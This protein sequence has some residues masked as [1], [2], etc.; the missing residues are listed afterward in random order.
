DTI[1]DRGIEGVKVVV[2]AR[3][4][5]LTSGSFYW[6]FKNIEDLLDAV[7]DYWENRL[8]VQIIED[9]VAFSGPPEQRILN[10]MNQVIEEDAAVPDS[11]IAVWAKSNGNAR[12]AYWRTMQRRFDFAAWMFREAGF[13]GA[14]AA[15]RGRMMVT[16]LMGETANGIGSN[17]GWR[18][19]I[20]HQWRILVTR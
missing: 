6:H 17:P 20:E 10:L 16:A 8:T 5:G 3:T 9:A 14:G 2:L 15:A 4:L 7:L 1:H 19:I 18:D 12:A 11:S 13:A